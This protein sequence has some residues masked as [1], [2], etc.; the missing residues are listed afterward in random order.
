ML[1]GTR[2]IPLPNPLL[3]QGEGIREFFSRFELFYDVDRQS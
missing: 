2:V 3:G 1:D